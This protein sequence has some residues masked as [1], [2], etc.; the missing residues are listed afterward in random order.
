MVFD[1]WLQ[2][3]VSYKEE[4]TLFHTIREQTFITSALIL[5]TECAEKLETLHTNDG[6]QLLW[7]G[8]TSHYLVFVGGGL[9]RI[10]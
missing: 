1:S 8:G 5:R 6:Y 2:W 4:E 10:N 9:A 3:L 7:V